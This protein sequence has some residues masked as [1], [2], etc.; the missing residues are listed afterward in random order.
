RQEVASFLKTQV[1]ATAEVAVR[2]DASGTQETF[3]RWAR[4]DVSELLKGLRIEIRRIEGDT[5]IAVAVLTE[6]TVDATDRLQKAM[7]KERPGTVEAT[8]EGSTIE[9]AIQ[10]ACRNA[11]EQV[12]GVSVVASDAS[13]DQTIRTR[14]FSDVQGTVSAYR[15]LEQTCTAGTHRV[16]IVATIDQ[17]E[18]QE[19]YGAQLKSIGDP[20]FFLTSK[21]DDVLRQMGDM[22]IGK[23]LK[24][25]THQG[26]ADYKVEFLTQ[27]SKV[28]HPANGR[29]GLQLQLTAV[30]YD[31]AGVQLFSL[32]GNPRKAAAFT[33]TE[34]R[35]AQIA[36]EKAVNQISKP[37]HA[38]LQR[39]IND[40]VNNGRAVRMIFRN[41]CTKEQ[42][43]IIEAL[44]A[45]INEMPMASSATYS[46][47]D[48]VAVATLRLTLKGNPQD[49]LGLLR[50]RVPSL[51]PAL[52][53]SA[54]KIVF[55]L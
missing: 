30:C 41:V 21:N 7:A 34:E 15:I 35:Q 14:A 19:T 17:D 11:L 22:F 27:C 18:L 38:R 48:A 47:N 25:T 43:A 44:T 33:G 26:E 49:F 16:R 9:L 31:K 42:C 37:L 54:N 36:A 53:V 10:V 28:K 1:A 23:G 32:Q 52:T 51:P 4:S 12:C 5:A 50:E 13:V 6:R 8:G 55:E 20:L 46:L 40:L 3:S 24:T 29:S 39:A 2:E 45:Q